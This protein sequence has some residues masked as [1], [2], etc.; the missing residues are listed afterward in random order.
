MACWVMTSRSHFALSLVLAID[1]SYLLFTEEMCFKA[2]G[3]DI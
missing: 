1:F 3:G 2:K